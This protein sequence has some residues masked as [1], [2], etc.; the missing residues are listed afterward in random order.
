M[1]QGG[2]YRHTALP[3]LSWVE[4]SVTFP[5]TPSSKPPLPDEAQAHPTW[6]LS[7]PPAAPS[8]LST[9][10]P[11]PPCPSVPPVVCAFSCVRVRP[12][13][14]PRPTTGKARGESRKELQGEEQ[15]MGQ[16]TGEGK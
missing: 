3:W 14:S 6:G 8:A 11:G 10:S 9:T 2:T 7:P 12:W 4:R 1:S 13:V 16:V 15:G 5:A